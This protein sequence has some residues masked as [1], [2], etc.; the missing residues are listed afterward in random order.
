MSA[1]LLP[2]AI[3]RREGLEPVELSSPQAVPPAGRVGYVFAKSEVNVVTWVARGLVDAGAISDGDWDERA[4]TPKPLKAQL[5]IFHTS[6]P[7]IRSL[8]VARR[9]LRPEVKARVREILLDMHEDPE[10]ADVLK[11]YYKVKKYDEIEGEV[12]ES[13]SEARRVFM[14]IR[15]ELE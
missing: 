11:A 15:E 8:I 1:F 5:E 10:G 14:F 2:L 3:L 9:G 12:A 4:R 7:F 13:L 6:K